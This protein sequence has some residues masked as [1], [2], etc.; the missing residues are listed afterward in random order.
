MVL[1]ALDEAPVFAAEAAVFGLAH[2]VERL[3]EMAHDVELVEQDRRLRRPVL[4]DVAERLP[5]VH[6]GELDFAAL[7]EPQPVVERRHAGLGAILAAEPD[8]PLANQVAHHDAIAVAL[9]DRD[10]VDAD[11][12]RTR[13]AGTIELDPHVLLLQRLDRVP[14]ELELLGH[15]ADRRLPA[16]AAD[17]ERKAFGEVRIVRQKIQPFALHC[18]TTAAR[19]APHFD[20]EKNPKSCAR[21]VANLPHPPVVPAVPDPL[22][23]AANRFFERRS[24][25]TI[26]TSGSPNT[27]RTVTFARKPANEYPSDRRRCRFPDLAISQHAKIEP[28]SKPRKSLSTSISAAMIP[29]ITHSIPRRPKNI[30]RVRT[31][32]A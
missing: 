7:F 28:A 5:H 23:T 8:R 15:I 10:L 9:A 29:Q 27:P 31:G 3:A 16:A 19:H 17:I 18:A 4:R 14:V 26:R 20:F 25:R 12:S 22:T 30:L 2:L 11:R 1:L 21:Q 32:S 6:H 13:R 24:S